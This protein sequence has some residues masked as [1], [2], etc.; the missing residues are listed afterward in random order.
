MYL[1][2]GLI[3]LAYC[4]YKSDYIQNIKSQMD[5]KI[6][7]LKQLYGTQMMAFP[8]VHYQLKGD[9]YSL[10]FTIDKRRGTLQDILSLLDNNVKNAKLVKKEKSSIKPM[11]ILKYTFQ[12]S[13][14]EFT[15]TLIGPTNNYF[16]LL[17]YTKMNEFMHDFERFAEIFRVANQAQ[18]PKSEKINPFQ[19]KYKEKAKG[20]PIENLQNLGARVYKVEEAYLDWDYLA[21]SE[22]AKREIEDTILL[23]LER[24]DIFDKITETTRVKYEKN[25]PKAVLFEGP[26]GTGKTT[27]AKII[28]NQVK[29]PLVYV[30]LEAIL[31]KYYG[32]AEGNLGKIFENC[33]NLGKCMIFI[34]EIDSLAQSR[35][36][37]MHE[38]TRRLL[39]VF[40]RYLDGF[41]SS[42]DII[43]I[44]ATNRKSDLDPALQNRFSKV[45]QFP[46]PDKHSRMAIFERYARHLDRGQLMNLAENSQNM[47]GRDIKNICEDAERKWAAFI[48]RG[49]QSDYKVPFYLY[50]A[51]LKSRAFHKDH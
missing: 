23:T 46:Y 14:G 3:A 22:E 17:E 29:V 4:D 16:Y 21:G 32:E 10:S 50:Q 49:E 34:D 28:S 48:L 7:E 6:G 51:S 39:S 25:R 26:P 18:A 19:P 9:N 24:P 11:E 15:I 37:E 35:E 2:R 33:I 20:D 31:S 44:C 40:L 8:E 38:A 36:K 41:E 30:R 43:V 27:S 13:K 45:I 1:F 12:D 5:A 42:D 47:S